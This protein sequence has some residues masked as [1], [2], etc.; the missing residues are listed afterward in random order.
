M[1]SCIYILDHVTYVTFMLSYEL[2]NLSI[3]WFK[4]PKSEF[5]DLT[6]FYFIYCQKLLIMLFVFFKEACFAN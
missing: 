4:R 3:F 6:I 1:E 5:L 2:E